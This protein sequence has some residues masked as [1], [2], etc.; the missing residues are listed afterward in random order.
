MLA[1]GYEEYGACRMLTRYVCTSHVHLYARSI[2]GWGLGL[3]GK[4]TS[5]RL[6]DTSES[7]G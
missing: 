4:S 5:L 3:C 2:P 1:L 6:S 7:N